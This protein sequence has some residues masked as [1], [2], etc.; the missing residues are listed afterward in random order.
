MKSI[1]Q[2]DETDCA[3]ACL[4]MILLHFG[5]EVPLR[6]IRNIAGTDEDG[7]SAFGVLKAA[8]FYGLSVKSL[9]SPEK[10][11]S[12][13]PFPAVLH[14]T[15]DN[16][17]HYVVLEGK[18]GAS[19]LIQDPASGSVKITE[20]E[21]YKLWTG[22]FFIFAPTVSFKKEKDK[23]SFFNF[24]SLLQPY[25]KTVIRVLLASIMLSIFGIFM[26]FYFR[27]LIDEVLYSQIKTTLNLCSLCYFIVILFQVV[28][29][30]CR[31]QLILYLGAK[32]DVTLTSDFFYHLLFLPMKF[33][34]TRK[35][36]EI[37]SRLNDVATIRNA[38]SSST[39]SVVIDSVMIVIGGTFLIKLG[40]TLAI[41]IIIPVLI[42]AITVWLLKKSFHRK[43]KEQ[44]I[45][46][47]EKNA[48]IY[49]SINGIST[50]KALST[51]KKA[52]ERC[53][54]FIVESGEKHIQLGCLENSQNLIQEFVSACGTLA[55]YWIGSFLIFDG[56]ITLGQ[57][58]SFSILSN[59]FLSPLTR[60][61]TMQAYWQEV[62]V[63]S[64]RLSDIFDENEENIEDEQK[65]RVKSLKG[66]IE[67]QDVAFSYGTRGT[68]IKNI[69]LKIP[70]GKKV[71]FVG[72]S[73]SGKSTLIKLLMQFYKC[74]EGKILIDGKDISEYK[75]NEYRKSIGYVPQE[76]LL[77]SGTIAEN[78]MWGSETCSQER[79]IKAAKDAQAYDFI[80]NLPQKFLTL[81]GEQGAS[82][83]GGER[84]RI[85]L[86][87]ILAG[88]HD[89]LILDEATACLD[90]ISEK[91][92]MNNVYSSGEK[93]VIMVAHRLSTIRNCDCIFVFEKGSLIEQGT[94]EELLKHNGKY[95]ELWR[96]QNEKNSVS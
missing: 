92:V 59:F 29:E 14:L 78:I 13:I 17:E 47:A 45:L 76:C 46:Q 62:F 24:V 44:A 50:I 72:A 56:K 64:E 96:A 75:T 18:K 25:K 93:T 3:A 20:E 83:S 95:K 9:V 90:S 74:N 16:M 61:L 36:G 26:S 79:M 28:M 67:F 54:E 7:T 6:K 5:K 89:I 37:L 69:S 49:E 52:F 48:A 80:E 87:R 91:A 81:V 27:F 35:T 77:F 32:I 88:E 71:A 84:Q 19:Y 1:L 58:I 60:L 94:H 42:S 2:H 10:N 68:T 21:L 15:I 23:S 8:E 39:L 30:Y 41:I 73:G 66:D 82:L 4:A 22:I 40:T 11:L 12:E 86:A 65:D 55:V 51:E 43:I 53:E 33:F 31:N 38:V 85:A 34:S 57:L 70:Y 63:S